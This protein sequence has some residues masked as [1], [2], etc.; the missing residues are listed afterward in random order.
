MIWGEKEGTYTNSER[1]VSKV[2]CAVN[3]PG[4]AKPDFE[5]FL[6]LSKKSGCYDEIFPGWSGS[7]DAFEEW[8]RV[9]AGRLCD[10]SGMMR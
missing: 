7:H 9:S 3:P 2:N 4:E 1:C 5:I 8:K 10:Y 6:M